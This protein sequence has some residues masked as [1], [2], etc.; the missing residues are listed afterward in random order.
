MSKNKNRLD[1]S[2]ITK[3]DK[4]APPPKEVSPEELA[5]VKKKLEEK[6]RAEVQK[7]LKKAN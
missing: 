4:D 5:E 3:F 7:M 2:D 6:L 1:D